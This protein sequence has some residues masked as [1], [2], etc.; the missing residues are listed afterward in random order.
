MHEAKSDKLTETI[1]RICD[2]RQDEWAFQ[3]KGRIST[4]GD[5]HA[6]DAVYHGHC[7]RDFVKFKSDRH[8]YPKTGRPANSDASVIFETVCDKLESEESEIYTVDEL[9]QQMQALCGAAGDANT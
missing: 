9:L 2:E 5:L 7:Q 4:R 3:V 8:F 6:V 1:L